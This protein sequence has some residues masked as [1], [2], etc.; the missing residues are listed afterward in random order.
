MKI[1]SIL[2]KPT[3]ITLIFLFSLGC[4]DNSS[5]SFH[6]HIYRDFDVFNKRGL[7][8]IDLNQKGSYNFKNETFFKLIK[9][10]HKLDSIIINNPYGQGSPPMS[11]RVVEG[12]S[13]TLYITTYPYDGGTGEEMYYKTYYVFSPK[14]AIRYTHWDEDDWLVIFINSKG[15]FGSG[16]MIAPKDTINIEKRLLKMDSINMMLMPLHEIEKQPNRLDKEFTFNRWLHDKKFQ[17]TWR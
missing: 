13:V 4:R 12:D 17:H 1:M 16:M 10:G 7:G 2:S 5:K 15:S 6:S 11:L 3:V 9:R 14:K 8:E